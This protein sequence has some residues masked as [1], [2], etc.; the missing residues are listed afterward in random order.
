MPYH[1]VTPI[2]SELLTITLPIKLIISDNGIMRRITS[3]GSVLMIVPCVHHHY[4][5]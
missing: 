5:I 4:V 3:N 2:R 1:L